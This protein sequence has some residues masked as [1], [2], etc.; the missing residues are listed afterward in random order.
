MT[1]VSA[2]RA[3]LPPMIVYEGA[4]VQSTW[5]PDIP[6]DS[7]IYPWL[8]ANSSGWMSSDTFYKWFEEWEV[9]T[10]SHKDDEL[11]P[12]LLI[13]NGHLSHIWYGTLELVRAQNVT[14]I[15]LPPHTTDLLL[16]LDVSVF[17]SLKGYWGDILFQRL[18]VTRSRLSKAEFATHLCDP[19][20]WKKAFSVENIKNGFRRRGIFSVDSIQYP[21]HRFSINLKIRYDKWV[22]EGKPDISAAEIDKL[23]VES[24]KGEEEAEI[25]EEDSSFDDSLSSNRINTPATDTTESVTIN[26]KKGKILSFL[27]RTKNQQ[28]CNG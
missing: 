9:K 13:Y 19:E 8:F 17:K 18:R 7:E 20:V 27:F 10:R 4:H 26:G 22:E 3:K 25:L 2:A 1:A 28:K 23:V 12:R 21:E 15:K 16:P 14:I 6:K 11:E 24:Q 5:R